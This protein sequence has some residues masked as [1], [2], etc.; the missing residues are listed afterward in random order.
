VP[1]MP[2]HPGTEGET[3]QDVLFEGVDHSGEWVAG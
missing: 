3:D 1:E 2:E